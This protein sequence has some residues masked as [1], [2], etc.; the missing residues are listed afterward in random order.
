M[1]KLAQRRE[2]NP[3]E[4]ITTLPYVSID[5]IGGVSTSGSVPPVSASS[6]SAS[7]SLL[8]ISYPEAGGGTTNYQVQ[9]QIVNAYLGNTA[10]DYACTV[11]PVDVTVDSNGNKVWTVPAQALSNDPDS[12]IDVTVYAQLIY[13]P[14]QSVIDANGN[15]KN[16]N[17]TP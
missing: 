17:L 13:T 9:L 7:G 11:G 1:T 2:G 15:S 5:T 8:R 3:E 12:S 14:S 4:L 6:F 10:T 16:F